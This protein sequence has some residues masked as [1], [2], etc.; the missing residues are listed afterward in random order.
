MK[1]T[2]LITGVSRGIGRAVAEQLSK[3][4]NLIYGTYN[5]GIKE[6]ESLK[7]IIPTISLFQVDLGNRNQTLDFVANLSNTKFDAI[8]NN[9]GVLIFEDFEKFTLDT[10]DK[11]FNVNLIAPLILSHGLRNNIISGGSI[12]NIVSTDGLTGSFKSMAYSASKAAL[13]NL[14]KSLANVYGPKNIRVNA[15]APRFVGTG[16]DSP[17]L[18]VAISM[19]PLGRIASYEEIANVVSFLV[20]DK[21]RFIN[22]ETITVD[23]GYA[24]VDSIMKKESES[25]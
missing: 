9:A 1:K 14:T 25:L 22:G 21:A 23:G 2:C 15:I 7:K 19:T 6:A 10:W 17:A 12:V 4:G 16:M 13:I 3:E 24:G 11:V 8:I 18:P 20:S 5:T